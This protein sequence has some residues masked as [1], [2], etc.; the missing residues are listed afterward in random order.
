VILDAHSHVH[1][2]LSDHI[3]LLDEAGIE[4][5]VLFGTRAHPERATDLAALRAEL[6]VLGAAL[7]GN[8]GAAAFA[9]ARQE[10]RAALAAYPERFIGFGSVPL[11]DAVDADVAEV[12]GQGLR[13][14]GEL[15]PP[16]D[17]AG[18]VEPVLRAA[19]D[20][21][22]L[23]VVVHGSAPT[24]AGDVA[25][26]VE[27][28]RRYPSVP[29]VISQLGGQHWL[30][31]V[32]AAR[33]TPNVYVDLSTA[34]V[35]FAVRLAIHEVPERTLFG[36]DAPYGDPVLARAAVERATAPGELRDRVLG[37]TLAELLGL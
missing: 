32:D 17:R 35:A 12:V 2:S 13:G 7:S 31:A 3:A 21:G 14:I 24:T 23:P 30:T 8:G 15:T 28:A 9:V 22:R 29:L 36:S 4:R 11:G 16:P 20:H 19:A 26:L 27:L 34:P 25:T 33:E 1:H 6:S 5:T 37:G 10:L 18:I